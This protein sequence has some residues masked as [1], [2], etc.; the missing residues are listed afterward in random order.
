MMAVLEAKADWAPTDRPLNVNERWVYRLL[1]TLPTPVVPQA[2]IGPFTVDFLLPDLRVVVEAD[3]YLYHLPP[4]HARHD[5]LRDHE[6]QDAGFLVVHVWSDDL[7]RYGGEGKLLE[8]VR[9]RVL[10]ARG[11]WLGRPDARRPVDRRFAQ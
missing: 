2:Q 7:Y 10:R 11:V 1:Q 3:S 5:R 6:L 4:E 9:R 8:H